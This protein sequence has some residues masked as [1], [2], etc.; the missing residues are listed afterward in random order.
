MK[1]KL[2][3]VVILIIW[4]DFSV[5]SQNTS[6]DINRIR[7][8]SQLN[9]NNYLDIVKSNV[10]DRTLF[11]AA[12]ISTLLVRDY[13]IQ[14]GF[15]WSTSN[16]NSMSFKGLFF[17][18]G[19]NFRIKKVPFEVNVFYCN[20]MFSPRIHETNWGFTLG[21]NSR[22]FSINL[23]DN[24]RIY[25]FT[26]KGI[27]ENGLNDDTDNS[28]VEPRNIMYSFTY[29][30]MPVDHKW[31][32]A[33]TLT[34]FDHFLI[35]QETNP[36]TACKLFYQLNPNLMLYSELWYQNA[37]LLNLQVNYFGYYIRTGLIWKIKG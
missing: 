2:K 10:I 34:N 32:A 29:F 19:G 25:K 16:Q 3:F 14:A 35:Q 20:N 6:Q 8:F 5:Y 36:M 30:V 9:Q 12:S 33:I 11:R 1:A 15:L 27:K 37:G 13:H 23:G 24:Y 26:N 18:I 31:N 22:H 7:L 28:I 21:Y 17:N 4:G